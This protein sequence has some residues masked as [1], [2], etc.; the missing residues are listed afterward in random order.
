MV[1]AGTGEG[2]YFALESG[3]IAGSVAAKAIELGRFNNEFLKSYEKRW[4]KSFE[5]LMKAGIIF[6][7]LQHIAFR[8][9][10]LKEL[11]IIPTDKEIKG[12]IS[13]GKVPLRARM[14]WWLY[15]VLRM[16]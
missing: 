13:D 8:K 14:V 5:K 12:M 1:Y 3:R 10:R 4:K 7:D 6:R 9:R 2:I 15:R 11:F 16:F